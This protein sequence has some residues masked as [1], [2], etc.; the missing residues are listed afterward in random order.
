[1]QAN[2][3]ELR[4]LIDEH[5]DVMDHEEGDV[6]SDKLVSDHYERAQEPLNEAAYRIQDA[7]DEAGFE[8]FAAT[9]VDVDT[10]RVILY[11]K[12]PLPRAMASLVDGLRSRVRV[13]VRRA[14]YSETELLAE[15]ERVAGL[16]RAQTGVRIYSVGPLHD[17]SGLRVKVEEEDLV[18]AEHVIDSP[19]RLEFVAGTEATLLSH[20][21][22]GDVSPFRGGAG[23]HHRIDENTAA[24]CTSGFVVSMGTLDG[25]TTADHCTETGW[26]W[27]TPD[28]TVSLAPPVGVIRQLTLSS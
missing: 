2:P 19:V 4:P 15:A 27:R 8:G 26:Q 10:G 25:V 7:A 20:W 24:Y 1:M 11:W 3:E 5:G 14:A 23:I 12:G 17:Y 18:R 22:W 28:G 6:P 21:R 13:E 9:A 16:D